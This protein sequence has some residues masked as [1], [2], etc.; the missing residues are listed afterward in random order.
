[1]D[2]FS[3]LTG[4]VDLDTYN[5]TQNTILVEF[6]V[7]GVTVGNNIN[8]ND[9]IDPGDFAEQSF[10]V[11]KADLGLAGQDAN[12]LRITMTRSGGVKPTVKFDDLQLETTEGVNPA[13]FKATTPFGTQFHI[14]EIRLALA[15]ELSG[16]V[17]VAGAT[18]NATMP[19]LSY[20]KIL[21]VSALTNGIT[22]SRVQ[23]GV[24]NFAV[25]LKQLGDFLGTGSDIT[26][27]I[28]DGTNTFISLIVKFPEPIILNGAENSFL[29]FTINDDL[30]GLK[31]FSASARGAI[32]I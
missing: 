27:V 32:E 21:G 17:T 26:S 9:F 3:A 19:G 22:F 31:Q 2:D 29:S 6:G 23:D 7:N 18:E 24:T 4:K 10:S 25:Q 12:D 15:D 5:S 11:P 30:S 1:M 28:S 13:V 20:D 8:L 16:I 14:T